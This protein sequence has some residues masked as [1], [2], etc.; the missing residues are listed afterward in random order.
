MYTHVHTHTCISAEVVRNLTG[1]GFVLEQCHANSEEFGR[2]DDTVGNPH[3]AQIVQFEPFEIILS[4]KLD[5]QF[6]VERFEATGS[7]S[8]VPSPPLRSSARRAASS[9]E[10]T[11]SAPGRRPLALP[12]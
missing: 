6:P 7:Q 3:R 2:G 11:S 4:L 8:T 10:P 5:R 1:L 12:G 9:S